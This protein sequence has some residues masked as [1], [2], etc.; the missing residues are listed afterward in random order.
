M[1]NVA[2]CIAKDGILHA[3]RWPFGRQLTAFWKLYWPYLAYKSYYLIGLMGLIG[4]ISRIQVIRKSVIGI[5][6][7]R[8][9]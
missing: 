4:Q 3:E 9:S 7:L 5:F 1:Q 6:H 2:F 8:V